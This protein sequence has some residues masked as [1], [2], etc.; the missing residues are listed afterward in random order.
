MFCV[1]DVNQKYE[2]KYNRTS[3][4]VLLCEINHFEL[5]TRKI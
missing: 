4:E 2:E 3:S 5:S 1:S